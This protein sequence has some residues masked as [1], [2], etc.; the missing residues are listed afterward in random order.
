VV[1]VAGQGSNAFA[2]Q[3]APFSPAFLIFSNSYVAAEHLNYGLLG[4]PGLL[5][6]ATTTPAAPG[7][8]VIL[9]GVGFGPTAPA[10]PT[11]YTVTAA[12]P[13]A[14][15]VTVTIG[16]IAVTPSFAGL[17]ASG[18]YQFNVTVPASL[19]TGNAAVSATIGGV[20][21]Q[22]GVLLAVQQ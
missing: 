18:L 20:T 6:G 11:G 7:E 5:A 13:L 14:N 12:E 9:Y 17:S 19:T 15:S 10:T 1:T 22:T 21:T 16:G 3:K 2:A 4:P 8:T